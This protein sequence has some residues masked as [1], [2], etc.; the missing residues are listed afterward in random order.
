MSYFAF[1][2]RFTNDRKDGFA[3]DLARYTISNDINIL[4]LKYF[5]VF[6]TEMNKN[7]LFIF[8]MFVLAVATIATLVSQNHIAFAGT[9]KYIANLSGQNEVPPA[10][11]NAT[12]IGRFST[13]PQF[14]NM[15]FGLSVNNIDQVT[16]AHIHQGKQGENGPIVVTLFKPNSPTGKVNGHLVNGSISN[17]MLEGPLKGKTVI[18]LSDLIQSGQAYVNVHTTKNPNGEIRG[19]LLG[20]G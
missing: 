15:S 17:S 11:T 9:E 4:T 13:V 2:N 6:C 14:S 3:I 18:D 19:Q 10:Q 20:R 12:G 7:K 5:V 1:L 8:S 16:G